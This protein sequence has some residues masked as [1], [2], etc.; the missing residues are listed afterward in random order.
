MFLEGFQNTHLGILIL[1]AFEFCKKYFKVGGTWH[2]G[3]FQK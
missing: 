1:I 3:W 2:S